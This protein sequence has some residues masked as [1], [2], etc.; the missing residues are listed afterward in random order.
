MR[1][2]EGHVGTG[3][4]QQ[5]RDQRSRDRKGAVTARERNRF[6]T[7][8]ALPGAALLRSALLCRARLVAALMG[9]AV[10][11]AAGCA[12]P[13]PAATTSP[14][15]QILF[16]PLPLPPDF[17]RER[18]ALTLAQIP[19]APTPPEPTRPV[20]TVELPRQAER[21]LEAARRLF[22]EQRYT[23]TTNELSTALRYNANIHEAHRL[24]AL[25][26]QLSGNEQN[27]RL[28]ADRALELNPNDAASL[29]VL[30]RL[31]EKA[32]KPAEALRLYRTALLC[33]GPDEDDDYRALVHHHLGMLLERRHYYTAAVEQLEAFERAVAV[34]GERADR[35]PELATLVRVQRGP[36]M[37]KLARAQGLL[38]RYAAAADT[39]ARA[40]EDQPRDWALRGEWI[41]MLARA[42]RQAEACAAASRYVADSRGRAEALDL[43]LAVYRYAGRPEEAVTAIHAVLNEQPDNLELHLFYVDALL[44]ADRRDD[45]AEALE[46]LSARHPD[47]PDVRWKLAALHRARQQWRDWLLVLAA[48]LVAQP[49]SGARAEQELGELPGPVAAAMVDEGVG[50]TVR[51]P[52]LAGLPEEDAALL[53][54]VDFLVA[55]LAARLER[56]EDAATLLE[57]SVQ[58]SPDFAPPVVALV[59]KLTE[60]CRWADGLAL[61]GRVP[62]AAQ[63]TSSVLEALKSRCHDGLDQTDAALEGYQQA[64]RLD[65]ANGEAM[66]WLA[67]LY[68]RTGDGAKVIEQYEAILAVDP[69]DVRAREELIRALWTSRDQRSRLIREL[70]EIQ[71]IDPHSPPA[72]RCVALVR[73][74]QPPAADLDAYTQAMRELVAE[75]PEDMRSR[76]ELI[77][78]LIATREYEAAQREA[79]ELLER[80]PCSDR[81]NELMSL[82]LI[83]QLLFDEAQRRLEQMLTWYPNR[84]TWIQELA[85]LRALDQRYDEAVA[86]WNRLLELEAAGGTAISAERKAL[87]QSKLMLAYRQAGRFDDARRT[88]EEWLAAAAQGD[89]GERSRLRWFVLAADAGAGQEERY[90][91][92]VRAW[93]ADEPTNAELRAWELGVAA[94]Y[95]SGSLGLPPGKAGLIGAKRFE[96]A[97][98]RA[99]EWL[100]ARPEDDTGLVWLITALQAAKRHDEAIELAANQVAA[101]DELQ[102]RIEHLNTLR[103]LYMRA[104]RYD[105]ALDTAR[106]VVNEARKLLNDIDPPRKPFVEMFVFELRRL[107]GQVLIQAG[108]Y[109]EAVSHLKEMVDEVDG[110][111]REAQTIGQGLEDPRQREM[112]SRHEQEA[113][114]RQT[115]L[116]RTLCHVHQ[117][118]GRDD[119]A[120]ERAREAYA[121]QPRDVGL[122]ND[123]GYTLADAGEDLDEA[124]RMIRYALST[125][126]AQAAYLDSYGWVLY[127]KGRFAEAR[128]WLVRACAMEEGEDPVIF[129]HLG[130]SCW[131]LGEKD[132]AAEHWRR[133]LETHERKVAEGESATDDKLVGRLKAKLAAVQGGDK[134]EVAPIPADTQPGP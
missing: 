92:R 74:L 60:E 22:A 47:L 1:H 49:S 52:L 21:R 62:G 111:R 125:E 43:L 85:Q 53:S 63:Q 91:E 40:M 35:N 87:Y 114:K 115:L 109:D 45:A 8:A 18:A 29:Y 42:G 66:W 90:I 130:D 72:V 113:A 123:V 36:G 69:D 93:L 104:Q 131:R 81:A 59:R 117:L 133:A 5:S 48:E 50:R 124:E 9:V 83:R 120:L 2:R 4:P 12:A 58:R 126:P 128:T 71:R 57:R 10:L 17:D 37:L 28:H 31:A 39:L 89:E 96:E 13:G 3:W 110:I 88:A 20:A 54:A 16:G 122:N 27:A 23:E 86:L 11:V 103:E 101:A 6:L 30:A 118:Q 14:E 112:A 127:K 32:D 25:A 119:L 80:H 76:E 70:N 132:E 75:H 116:L 38:G 134:P 102:H 41:R 99:F 55:R 19:D 79:G 56:P 33:S 100:A 105:Q 106:D 51:E 73:F 107:F 67:R 82:V 64:I 94:P 97:I 84:A 7:G 34:L 108:R 95:P 121:L 26:C 24:M 15:D 44:A 129:D 65:Q 77:G 46:A 61:L 68:E 98:L 78:T